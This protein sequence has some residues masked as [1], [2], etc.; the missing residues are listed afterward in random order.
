MADR[1]N[2]PL[3]AEESDRAS[4]PSCS[5]MEGLRGL[6]ADLRQ[7]LFKPA[8]R[9]RAPAWPPSPPAATASAADVPAEKEP[10]A[11]TPRQP[12]AESRALLKVVAELATALWR[13]RRRMLQEGEG[14]PPEQ[15][16]PLYRYVE[17]AWDALHSARA[18]IRDHPGERYV[19]G[20]ALNVIVFQP[21]EGRM[22]ETIEETVKPSVFFADKLIQRGEVIVAIPPTEAKTPASEEDQPD[23]Q[24]GGQE[25]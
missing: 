1:M 17:S 8:F 10:P 13:I 11:P 18:E 2:A 25:N 20:L 7:F 4:G 16:R 12:G 19:A 22:D 9:I 24:A 3:N 5:W 14:K 6:M 23:K 15:W 21:R